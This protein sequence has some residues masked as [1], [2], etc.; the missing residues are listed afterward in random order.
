MK[1]YRGE[2]HGSVAALVL[3]GAFGLAVLGGIGW[4]AYCHFQL[5][6]QFAVVEIRLQELLRK[7]DETSPLAEAEVAPTSDFQAT[8]LDNKK[9]ESA[10]TTEISTAGSEVSARQYRGTA[11]AKVALQRSEAALASGDRKLAEIYLLNALRHGQGQ[12]EYLNRYTRFVL[13]SN[14]PSLEE[15]DRLST[16]LAQSAYQ[17]PPAR[18]NETLELVKQVETAR[19]S[20]L[21]KLNSSTEIPSAPI[22]AGQKTNPPQE[23]TGA[24]AVAVDP[25]AGD[26]DAAVHALAHVNRET[27]LDPRRL[28]DH[29]EHLR[30]L[31]ERFDLEG[32]SGPASERLQREMHRAADLAQVLAHCQYVDTC[33]RRLSEE[34]ELMSDRAVAVLQAAEN[35]LPHFWGKDRADLPEALARKVDDYPARVQDWV[36]R[37]GQARSAPVLLELEKLRDEAL[38]HKGDTQQD[39][40]QFVEDKMRA[41]QRLLSR[42]TSTES[43]PRAQAVIEQL[44]QALAKNR[45]QQYNLYQKQA[46]S[47]CSRVF[48]SFNNEWRVNQDEAWNY[49]R[50]EEMEKIDPGLLAPDV[51]R[52]YNDLLGKLMA[53]MSPS[54]IVDTYKLLGE[55][56]KWKLEDF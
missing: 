1:F 47:R 38:A 11:A 3:Q 6:Q 51:S 34:K 16:L 45:K 8:E 54:Y 33:L 27:L 9:G 14:Q 29:R 43:L 41:A 30:V 12:M 21:T 35:T 22:D 18:V 28:A 48:A 42:L 37:L 5:Q 15:L 49:I 17:V 53:K 4:L 2:R 7:I 52:C 13:E 40:C 32:G 10:A 23:A 20:L 36:Q 46:L 31:A 56:E 55:S 39:N 26:L 50:R 19:S 24:T 25:P 44:Q